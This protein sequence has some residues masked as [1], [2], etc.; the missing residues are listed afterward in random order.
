M[1]KNDPKIKKAYHSVDNG[2]GVEL[3]QRLNRLQQRQL[4]VLPRAAHRVEL[5]LG[6]GRFHLGGVER[7]DV[8]F[9]EISRWQ[10]LAVAQHVAARRGDAASV[11]M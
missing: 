3:L 9:G 11:V 10:P 7:G 4:L 5:L 8:G 1:T 6:G 2:V